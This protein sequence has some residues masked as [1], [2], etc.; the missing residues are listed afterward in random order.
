[1]RSKGFTLVELI[2]A[3]MIMGILAGTMTLSPRAGRQTARK[4]AEK[5]MA[6]LVSAVQRA[7]RMNLSFDFIVADNSIDIKWSNDYSPHY[8]F[9]TPLKASR[10]CEYTDNT[11]S[12]SRKQYPYSAIISIDT[13]AS[14]KHNIEITGAGQSPYRVA[15]SGDNL[16]S[17]S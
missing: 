4:E 2:I 5:V 6:L 8:S 13:E 1:M 15:I 14:G 7:D 10:G 16:R 12:Y 17:G 11:F 3:I 9:N